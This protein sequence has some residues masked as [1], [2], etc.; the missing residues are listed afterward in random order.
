MGT[1]ARPG[2]SVE[3]GNGTYAE[4]GTR[5]KGNIDKLE[6]MKDKV[7]IIILDK[8]NKISTLISY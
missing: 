3:D 1:I 5:T 8:T 2:C 6:E 7:D 4:I